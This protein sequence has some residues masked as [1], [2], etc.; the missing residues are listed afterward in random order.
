[1]IYTYKKE[2]DNTMKEAFLFDLKNL[3]LE[4]LG[5]LLL[6][7]VLISSVFI[8]NW[9]SKRFPKK[10]KKVNKKKYRELQEKRKKYKINPNHNTFRAFWIMVFLVF[11][12]LGTLL[13]FCVGIYAFK[14]REV[15]LGLFFVG[16][17][18]TSV[19]IIKVLYKSRYETP[20][21]LLSG[22]K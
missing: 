19:Y 17:T 1:M 8:E 12:S 11:F 7:A 14:E 6:I 13:M 21:K 5:I 20:Y 3:A 2:G 4:S 9:Y 22:R 16:N 18:I 15:L 10:P